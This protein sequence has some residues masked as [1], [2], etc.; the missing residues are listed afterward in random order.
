MSLSVKKH[1]SVIEDIPAKTSFNK[2]ALKLFIE[3]SNDLETFDLILGNLKI[4]YAIMKYHLGI[5]RHSLEIFE[6][7]ETYQT[8]G[9]GSWFLDYLREFIAQY[10][11]CVL[12]D[13]DH[14][15]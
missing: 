12:R 3:N 14:Q 4:G 8:R 10:H 2:D 6:M 11:N 9:Y 13:I 1:K 15:L 5:Q 7:F